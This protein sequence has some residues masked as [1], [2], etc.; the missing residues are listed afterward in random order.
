[1]FIKKNYVKTIEEKIFYETLI[2][3]FKKLNNYS[4][5]KIKINS[6]N[7]L[8]LIKFNKILKNYSSLNKITHI[9]DVNIINSNIFFVISNINNKIIV[10]C[11][12]KSLNIKNLK[13]TKNLNLTHIIN[14][15]QTKMKKFKNINYSLHI[16]GKKKQRN[17]ILYNFNKYFEIKNIKIFNLKP[18]NGCRPKKI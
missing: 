5:T 9:I 13:K 3:L 12:T 7:V 10:K 2:K 11:S 14:K 4:N 15:L 18:F 1:M 8:K 17:K 6:L 16:N